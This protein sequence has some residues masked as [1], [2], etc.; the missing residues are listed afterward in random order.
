MTEV[1]EEAWELVEH[2]LVDEQGF[3]ELTFTNPVTLHGR[4]NPDFFQ[5]TVV[6]AA[7]ERELARLNV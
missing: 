2:E 6:E 5:G 7:A 1:L 3:R 4:M